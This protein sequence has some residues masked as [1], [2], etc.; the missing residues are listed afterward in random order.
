MQ[1]EPA[2]AAAP[3]AAAPVQAPFGFRGL[4]A[5]TVARWCQVSGTGL[6]EA[7]IMQPALLTI[8]AYDFTGSRQQQGG[9]TFFVAIRCNAQGTRARAK[10][11]DNEDG[12]YTV[13]HKPPSAGEHTARG[14]RQHGTRH[15][16]SSIS[17]R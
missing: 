2:E 13:M 10:I 9:D 1:D 16:V 7:S 4:R 3:A 6:T 12:S 14:T 8:E 15:T 5:P 11:T 17:P